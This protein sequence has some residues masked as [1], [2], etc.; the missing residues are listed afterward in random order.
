MFWTRHRRSPDLVP[1]ICGWFAQEGFVPGAVS[2]PADGVGV[3]VH[4]FLGEPRPL[5]ARVTMFAFVD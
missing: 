3:G 5:P 2:S 1:T 4:R